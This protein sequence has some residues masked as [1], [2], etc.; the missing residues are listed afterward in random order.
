MWAFA[1]TMALLTMACDKMPLLAPH[2]STISVSA[3]STVVQANGTTEIRATVLEASKTPVQNGTTVTFSTTLGLVAP[4]EARTLNGVATVQFLGNG[5]S[6]KASIT[7][8]SGGAAS[9]ALEINVG[10]AA[11]TRVS[12]NATPASVPPTGGTTVV[13]ALVADASGNPL[14]GVPVTFATTA[15]NFSAAVVNTDSSGTART[16]LSTTQQASVTAT[17][18]GVTSSALVV[19]VTVRPT[20]SIAVAANATP[21]VGVVTPFTIGVTP[22]TSGG[23]PI[24]SVTID[25]GD[26]SSDELGGVSGTAIPVQHVYDDDGSH[27]VT[28]TAQDSAGV[29]ATA[30]TVIFVQPLIVSITSAVSSLNA[31]AYSF[32]ANINPT[33]AATSIASYAW[34]FGD[35]TPTT[36]T[37][38]NVAS[39]TY[40]TAG[41]KTVRVTVRTVANRTFTGTALISV[42]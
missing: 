2:E 40:A 8:I 16:T 6:G 38:T 1:A 22:A 3:A 19:T 30:S 25:Y 11:A 12:L 35:N 18:G 5:Q 37:T 28:V 29:P 17:A 27:T 20:V 14:G 42:Q 4:A 13:S 23:L 36:N 33:G 7:A 9:T 24:Q 34:T 15:G 32:T 26:G 21:A 39:H 10:A 31:K 41:S